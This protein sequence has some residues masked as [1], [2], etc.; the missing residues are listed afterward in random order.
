[1]EVRVIRCDEAVSYVALLGSLNFVGVQEIETRFL[2]LT[3]NRKKPALIDMTAVD[4]IGSSGVNM[5]YGCARSLQKAGAPV[6]L[7]KP[8]PM[9][10]DTLRVAGLETLVRLCDDETQAQA[11][12]GI[13]KK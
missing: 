13:A 4:F 2:G 1:M 11:A 3:A 8:Q 5:L 6:V 7:L 12:L 10:A 9:V